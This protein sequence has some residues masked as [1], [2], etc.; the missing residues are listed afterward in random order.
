MRALLI[1]LAIG[2]SGCCTKNAPLIQD[3]VPITFDEYGF[4]DHGRGNPYTSDEIGQANQFIKERLEVYKVHHLLVVY[5]LPTTYSN[6][7]VFI[8]TRPGYEPSKELYSKIR[9]D[10]DHFLQSLLR[11]RP[12]NQKDERK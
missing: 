10:L 9:K 5:L 2:L 11:T 12:W 8:P 4:P 7:L 1:S 3:D 6:R